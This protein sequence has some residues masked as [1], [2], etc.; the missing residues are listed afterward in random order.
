MLDILTKTKGRKTIEVTFPQGNFT[1]SSLQGQYPDV[2]KITL[3]NRVNEALLIGKI[4]DVGRQD[5]E[6]KGRKPVIYCCA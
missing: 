1:I 2:S 5:K 4:Q 3:Q 6:G